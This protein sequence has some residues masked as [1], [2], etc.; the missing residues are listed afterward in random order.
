[1]ADQTAEFVHQTGIAAD[2]TQAVRA[3]EAALHRADSVEGSLAEQGEAKEAIRA[4]VR[5]L[6]L[7]RNNVL[8]E[9]LLAVHQEALQEQHST[10]KRVHCLEGYRGWS[11]ICAKRLSRGL[12]LFIDVSEFTAFSDVQE[13]LSYTMPP[14]IAQLSGAVTDSETI[15][16][17]KEY[18]QWSSNV[19]PVASKDFRKLLEM[20][21]F[22]CDANAANY[23]MSLKQKLFLILL[24]DGEF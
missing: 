17:F 5:K 14:E 21:K 15:K 19:F 6:Q 13:G 23:T 10:G 20:T 24:V 2:T 8:L 4:A 11:L 16:G 22:V 1:M 3:V 18:K 9:Q 7:C 12:L